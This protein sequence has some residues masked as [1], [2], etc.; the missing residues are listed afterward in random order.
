MTRWGDTA[1]TQSGGCTAVGGL[2]A[3]QRQLLSMYCALMDARD[4]VFATFVYR[5]PNA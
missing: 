4:R 5:D 3:V 2:D 1:K